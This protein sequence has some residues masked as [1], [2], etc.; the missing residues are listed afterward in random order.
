MATFTLDLLTGQ[1]HLFSFSGLKGDKGDPG[2]SGVT[3]VIYSG[4]TVFSGVSP[5]VV[6]TWY[7]GNTQYVS[8]YTPSG[9]TGAQGQQG[10]PGTSGATGPKGD[11]GQT[12]VNYYTFVPSG[13]TLISVGS[14]NTVVIY[15]PT[16][17]TGG[18]T[19]YTF[20][21]SGS[22]QISVNGN[23]VTIYS[24][25]ATGSTATW[26]TLT[27]KP[28][29]LTG[30]TL[31]QFEAGHEHDQYS[32]TGHTHSQYLTGVTWNDVANKPDLTLQ[33]DFSTHTGDT[34]IHYVQSAITITESQV[35]NLVS[36]LAS[37]SNTGHTHSQYLTISAF[38]AYSGS[39]FTG[40]TFVESGG[41][42]IFQNGNIVTIYSV[43]PSGS[44][45]AWND[46]T[47]KPN[48]T[49]QSDFANHTGD[50]NIHYVQSAITIIESQVVNLIF[51][52]ASK[53]NTGHTHSQYLTGVTW[54]SVANKPD[55]V[56]TSTFT[57][58]TANTYTK[59]EVDNL[60][61]G[62]TTGYTFVPSGGTIIG[63]SGNIVTIYSPTGG[64]DGFTGH[65]FIQSGATV[66]DVNGNNVTIYSPSVPTDISGLT[67]NSG[68]LFDKQY[69][70]LT[71][72]PDLSVYQKISGFTGHTSDL[73][74]HYPQS[75]ITI[76]QSQVTGLVVA[77]ASKSNTGHTHSYTGGSI[78]DLPVLFTGYTFVESG[79]TQIFQNGNIVTIY[80]VVPS[81]ST[82][83]WN[84][85]TGKPNLTLQSDFS[86]HTGQTGSGSIHFTGHTF[87]ASGITIITQIGDN[88][89]I[90][91]PA[92]SI[93]GVTWGSITSKPSWL[94]G[95]TAIEF[96]S[97]HTHPQYLTGGTN[98]G[99]TSI[100]YGTSVSGQKLQL[101]GLVAA[102]SKIVVS[103]GTT[104]VSVG[105]GNVGLND[106]SDVTITSPTLNNILVYSGSNFIN[107]A[108]I[109]IFANVDD[110]E[111]LRRSGT[112]I[113]GLSTNT[114][115]LTG[116]THSYTGGSITDLPILFTGYTFVQSGMTQI[117]V[118][119][120]EVTI[121]TNPSGATLSLN[122]LSDVT[123]TSP[124]LN[125]I[126]VYSGS[127]FINKAPIDIFANV[128]DLELL[129]RSGT[130]IVGLAMNEIT[131]FTK[132]TDFTVFTGTT[133]PN[134]YYN[135]NQVNGL[136]SGFTTGYTFIES[137]ATIINVNNDVVTIYSP[138]G[139]SYNFYGSGGTIVT[140][141]GNNVTIYSSSLTGETFQIKDISGNTE[142]NQ[143]SGSLIVWTTVDYNT[144]NVNYTGGSQIYITQN[145]TYG[146]GYS[147]NVINQTT[148]QKNIG[149]VIR[150]NGNTDITPTTSTSIMTN[151]TNDS[152][153]NLSAEYQIDLVAGDYI[154]LVAFRIGS[155]GSALTVPNGS[156]LTISKNK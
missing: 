124:T 60:I 34:T 37:K 7:S 111:L 15:S 41:T 33:S 79:G 143:I 32:L 126:L 103:G 56:L 122:D 3:T 93:T 91:V 113:I 74:I 137:G 9:A 156:W 144:P 12:I 94:T 78:T 47:G 1:E 148:Q 13:G 31:Q 24:V 154:E 85:V 35:V 36:D 83:A 84:D 139:T 18:F 51:D 134:N 150:K 100:I 59:N 20:I 147:L 62:F 53:S 68:L 118:V 52:L 151:A 65:T 25:P 88:V 128:D 63:I 21:A 107:K 26:G 116:H 22:T 115:S 133:L 57:G 14:G 70:G 114:F 72:T 2:A 120:N 45:V 28:A 135:K 11:S 50:T 23:Y 16:G 125:N 145:G 4:L 152:G 142:V 43:V 108:P 95:N 96:A 105:L 80:S 30:T 38:T 5:T 138:S 129:R 10:I 90:Y 98:M 89:N 77:L 123:I 39:T 29:W 127:N 58:Y 67:D 71:G 44:T 97:G 73:T 69:S 6:T 99:T 54:N 121:Y 82:V 109:D 140:V 55:L 49:L 27:G 61:S 102:D 48:L 117:S 92:D 17:A 130:T 119:D 149:T 141:D 101:K 40:Y 136:I 106:L 76:T 155:S 112:T 8:I 19:G 87:T 86:A 66:I 146:I 131:G 153:T 75:A 132:T 64:T 81:G 104:N 42:Q 110:L 46:V